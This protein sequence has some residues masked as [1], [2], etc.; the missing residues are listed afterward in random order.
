MP[1]P[2][3]VTSPWRMPAVVTGFRVALSIVSSIGLP[4]I[5]D[6][7]RR[8]S[9][10]DLCR[11]LGPPARADPQKSCRGW[12]LLVRIRCTRNTG[13]HNSETSTR[14]PHHQYLRRESLPSR[15]AE[16]LSVNAFR[17]SL[18]RRIAHRIVV[19]ATPCR[20]SDSGQQTPAACRTATDRL[21]VA[22]RPQVVI[23]VKFGIAVVLH[24]A[25]ARSAGAKAT[26]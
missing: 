10:D 25:R 20:L 19:T 13:A 12:S 16:A 26:P 18:S 24:I 4:S 9:R 15:I 11:L 7:T 22:V 5:H 3:F 8:D 2:H 14:Q 1:W 23:C 21:A 17:V 6:F